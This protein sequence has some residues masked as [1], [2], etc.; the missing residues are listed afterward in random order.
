MKDLITQ[1]VGKQLDGIESIDDLKGDVEA[2]GRY[3]LLH[4]PPW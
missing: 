4:L 2:L 3:N 1:I